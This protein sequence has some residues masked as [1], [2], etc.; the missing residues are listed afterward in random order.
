[1]AAL[2]GKKTSKDE[3]VLIVDIEN[4]SVG[5]AL[6]RHSPGSLPKLFAEVR[7]NT[8]ILRTFTAT[9]LLAEIDKALRHALL[10]VSTTAA[11]M[12]NHPKLQR[13]GTVQ[14]AAVFVSSPWAVATASAEG[15]VSD[16]EPLLQDA[17]HTAVEDTFGSLP[18]TFYATTS[19]ATH[20]TNRLFSESPGLLLCFITGEIT[21]LSMV[22]G[23]VSIAH[24]TAPSGRHDVLRTLQTH[25]GLSYEEAHSS[26]LLDRKARVGHATSEALFAAAE[27]FVEQFAHAA[28][29]IHHVAPVHGI[30][31]IAP[32]PTGEWA[33][34]YLAG[35]EHVSTLFEEGTTV[36]ALHT[37]HLAPFLAAH[38]PRP[39]L[40]F[41]IEAVFIDELVNAKI[42]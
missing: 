20:T 5:A 4:G 8:P 42:N 15:L 36:Q 29:D 32:E 3:T 34:Q 37:H 13:V 28:K 31:V 21:E 16:I 23:G 19:A 10:Q 9:E 2:F 7:V 26:L 40:Y 24:A 18:V 14:R 11:R 1:M 33:A 39:D 27:H 35:S 41:M 25:A 38:A 6:V 17:A 30:L 22:N 12:R